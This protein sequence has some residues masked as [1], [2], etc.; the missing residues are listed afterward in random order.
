MKGGKEE[1]NFFYLGEGKEEEE[2]MS[3]KNL[4]CANSF[5]I[6]QVVSY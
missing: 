6:H 5:K 1:E 2:E 4:L 3:I